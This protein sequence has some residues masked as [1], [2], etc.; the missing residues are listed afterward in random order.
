[1]GVVL[2]IAATT[3]DEINCGGSVKVVLCGDSNI[4]TADLFA[5]WSV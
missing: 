4:A 5:L 1:M 2:G 3:F